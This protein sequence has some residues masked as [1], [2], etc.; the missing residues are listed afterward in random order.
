MSLNGSVLYS[1]FRAAAVIVAAL[2]IAGG[3]IGCGGGRGIT[4]PGSTTGGTSGS[5]RSAG[6]VT[7]AVKW[8]ARSADRLVPLAANSIRI[9]LVANFTPAK[10]VPQPDLLM[11]PTGTGPFTTSVTV[12]NL[13]LGAYTADATA[14]PNADG[15][16]AAQATTAAAALP[17]ASVTFTAVDGANPTVALTM[18]STIAT[19]Q[20]TPAYPGSL[21]VG[22]PLQLIF[23][24][25]DSDGAVVL[26]A[27]SK[28]AYAI[29]PTSPNPNAIAVD[30]SSGLVTAKA[31]G[32]ATVRATDS[33]SG[34]SATT[35]L[36]VV[37][38][39]TNTRGL[40]GINWADP[41]GNEAPARNVVPSGLNSSM[42]ASQAAAVATS[43]ANALK[44]SG[45]LTIRMPIS[46]GTTSD[47]SYWPRYQAAINAVVA[48]GCNVD[49][50]F[51]IASNG[52][53]NNGT[54]S[55]A[56][57]QAMWDAVDA[58]YKNNA[59]V[60]YEPLNEPYGYND[61]DLTNLYAGFVS[62]YAPT[63][64][65]CIFDGTG[66]ATYVVPIGNDARLNNQ[67]L[68]LHRYFWF[69]PSS[70]NWNDS[71]NNAAAGVGTYASRTVITEMGVETF[72]TVDFWWQ[73]SQGLPPDVSF[74]TG[75]CAYVHDNS[76]GSMAWS[77]VNDV[78][79]YRWYMAADNLAEVNPGV[80]NMYRWS[81]GLPALWPQAIP[82]GVYK[83]QNRADGNMLDNLGAITNG[84]NVAQWSASASANQQWDI[85]YAGGYYTLTCLTGGLCLDNGGNTTDGSN[86]QQ[87]PNGTWIDN[88]H[89]QLAPTDSG[90]YRLINKASG[91]CLDTGGLTVNGSPLQ[92]WAP[93]SSDTQQWK[94]VAP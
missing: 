26:T 66:Y 89:W 17:A 64:W 20:V 71:Y 59:H 5:V 73:W 53:L 67:Y 23:T 37:T 57:W 11:R 21:R 94:F 42:T 61:T 79:S 50:C 24:A 70:G 38:A 35:T 81:W 65:K 16:G 87:W 45:G 10:A 13:E 46:Y 14:Y 80:A 78:D 9:K 58:V 63:S 7:F 33:E 15:T 29:D 69:S 36:T 39:P 47:A 25:F 90:Y 56:H 54:D 31:P 77:G 85:T 92:L 76:M 8:P 72:R 55:I 6:A 19:V 3:S 84:S 2:L 18:N 30:A 68:G 60:Y 74:L 12:N 22:D 48:A 32:V 91:V 34:K 43:I 82:N 1:R 40:R 83:L 86:C 52:N 49:L 88:Q 27:P 4:A 51:W 44:V 62:R 41:N 93:R 28:I 75:T